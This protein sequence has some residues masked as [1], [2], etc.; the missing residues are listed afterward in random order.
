MRTCLTCGG[1]FPDRE[2]QHPRSKSCLTCEA[3]AKGVEI[4]VLPPLCSV[5]GKERVVTWQDSYCAS[6]NV[7][8]LLATIT[9][10]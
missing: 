3:T 1:Y 7:D 4:N 10:E 2:Y 5:C 9:E 8:I 6:C